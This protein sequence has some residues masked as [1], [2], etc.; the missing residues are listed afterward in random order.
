MKRAYGNPD[1]MVKVYRAMPADVKESQIRNGDWVT[2]SRR[3]AE[4]HGMMVNGRKKIIEAEVPAKHLW[5]DGNDIYE[6][7]YDDGSNYAFQNTKNNRKLLDAVTYNDNGEVIPLS[8]RFNKRSGDTR[9]FYKPFG[10]NSGYVGY[11]KSKKTL[12]DF[13]SLREIPFPG[14]Q[15]RRRCLCSVPR[16]VA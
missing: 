15:R 9:F 1:A 12:R 16:R 10:G 5:T 6:W 3:Y 7:G 14:R 4:E 2:T 13:A 11:S 8:K